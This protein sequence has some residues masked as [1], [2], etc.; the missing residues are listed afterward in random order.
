MDDLQAKLRRMEDISLHNTIYEDVFRLF[1]KIF[2]AR[3]QAKQ[4]LPAPHVPADRSSIPVRLHEGFTLLEKE[5]LCP[6]PAALQTYFDRLLELLSSRNQESVSSVRKI[7]SSRPDGFPGAFRSML[8]ENPENYLQSLGR[9]RHFFIFVFKEC[10]RPLLETYTA[11]VKSAVSCDT[12]QEGS[13]PVCGSFPF[14]AELRGEEGKRF[15]FCPDCAMEW[16]PPR[17]KCPFCNNEDQQKMKYFSDE[18]AP[19]YRVMVCT[20]CKRYLKTVDYRKSGQKV[21]PE[22]EN[23]ATLHLDFI[24]AKEGLKTEDVLTQLLVSKPPASSEI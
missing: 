15:L 5:S 13:C 8:S 9:E 22:V 12:W 7:I 4:K 17:M 19:H 23:L 20:S 21:F 3:E 11:A 6:D 18:A 24:A 14:F 1:E 16:C 2:V 10:I